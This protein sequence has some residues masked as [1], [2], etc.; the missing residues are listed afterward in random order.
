[1]RASTS[2]SARQSHFTHN[3]DIGSP[4]AALVYKPTRR[5]QPLF[6][7]RHVVQSVGREPVAGGQQPGAWP[8]EKDR[9]FEVGGK[10]S[11]LDGLLSLTAAVFNT[12][13]T[14]ARITDPL[15][16]ALQSLAGTERVN[17]FEFGAQ[18]R[19]TENWE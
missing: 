2:R 16:P 3:D 18:G 17:G 15:N 9:T 10:C 5:S 8:P 6:L 7:L 12:E 4:R 1:M 14:N 19:I 13:K 11:V